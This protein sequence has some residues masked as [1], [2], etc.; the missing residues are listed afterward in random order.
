MTQ[1]S[2]PDRGDPVEITGMSL[3]GAEIDFADFQGGVTVVNVW[4][5]WCPPCRSETPALVAAAAEVDATF[6]GI[7]IRES[8]DTARAFERTQEVPYPSIHDEGG[9]TLLEFGRY[10]PRLPPTTLV[11]DRS[12]RVAALVSGAIPSKTTL[13]E[14]VEEVAAEDG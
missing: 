12:G 5:S 3:D 11:L 10:T 1:V 2:I 14:L 6:I 13:A 4:A 9:E 7:N 8:A